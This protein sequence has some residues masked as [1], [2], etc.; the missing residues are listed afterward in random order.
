M[1]TYRRL[2]VHVSPLYDIAGED[3]F[4]AEQLSGLYRAF[5]GIA[6]VG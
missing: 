1:S 2:T 5:H 3:R 4:D 6:V